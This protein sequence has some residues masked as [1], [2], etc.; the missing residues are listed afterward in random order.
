MNE[1]ILPTY[2]R[3]PVAFSR[4]E[5]IWLFDESGEPYMDALSGI[6]VCGLGHAHPRVSE[7]LSEQARTL[8]HTSNLYRIPLQERL[9]SELTAR[10]QMEKVF[11]CNSGAEANEAAI[12]LA[13]KFGHDKGIENPA[14]IVA[15]GSFHGRTMGAL[16]ATGNSKVH[17]GFTPLV[18]G[19]VRVPYDDL[20]AVAQCAEQDANIVAVL[21]EPILGEGGV[22]V[23]GDGYLQGLR[24]LCDKHGWLLL[25]DEV[26]TGMGR[27]GRW[28]AHQR[29]G[30]VPDVMMLAK[31]LGNG[32]P[33]GALLVRGSAV[34]VLGP[35]THGS[36]FGGSPL[37]CSAALAVIDTMQDEGLVERAETAG[38]RLRDGLARALEGVNSVVEIRGHGLMVGVQLNRP[39]TELSAKACEQG[40]LLNITADSVLRLLPPLV[41]SDAEV[42]ELVE[43]VSNLIKSWNAG[44]C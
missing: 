33:I 40:L 18:S 2:A 37:A 17:A 9:A 34:D 42:D 3:L 23:P 6:A 20:D 15:N 43:R 8:V 44:D 29:H 28:F 39:C 11:F 35:G 22:V 16:S 30:I 14:V 38:N 26:Q 32:V 25:L 13:R 31:A 19:F 4:G 10:A 21:V 36:T 5:G 7:A 12:K 1:S 27:T 24:E 41:I